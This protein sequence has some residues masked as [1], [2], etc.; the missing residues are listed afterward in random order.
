MGDLIVAVV[1]GDPRLPYAYAVGGRF[2]DEERAA[3]E[4]LHTALSQLE[5]YRFT[6]LDH[7]ATLIDDLRATPYDLALNLCDTGF[8]NHWEL[9]RDIPA[10]L[11]I[12]GIPYT[13]ADPMSISLTTDK[14]LVRVLA[15]GQGIPVPNETYVALAA[16]PLVL[17]S[18]YPCL[19]KP[20]S[21]GGSFGITR[22]CV[23]QDA[24]EAERYLRWL[25]A[26]PGVADALI[27]DFLT[28]PEYT[29]GLVGNPA[30]GFT[31]L[32]PLEIDYSALDPQLPP[33]LTHG[34]KADPDSP[35][36]ARL[37]FRRAR[38]DDVK[39]SQLVDYSVTLFR[40]LGLRDYARFDFREG[41][42]GQ[43]RLLDVNTNP[44]W[45]RDGKLALMAEWAGHPYQELLR[46]ILEAAISRQGLDIGI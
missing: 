30:T 12:L 9:E 35:Y 7:H 10:L 40:R 13:G 11:E 15:A 23:V 29:V 34:S 33:I 25:A 2:G 32:P 8:R 19:I 5:G 16:D 42:D 37:Q 28:G 36:W 1:L 27:Q 18:I 4:H 46:L 43:P 3:V 31:V 22:D 44:T 39:R 45:Y 6:Y 24:G 20:N 14:A 41:E 17:P 21:S 38:I 26:Q